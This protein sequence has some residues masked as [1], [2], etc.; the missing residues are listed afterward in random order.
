MKKLVFRLGLALL[1]SV[2]AVC[3]ADAAFHSHPSIASEVLWEESNAL[4]RI[5]NY[6]KENECIPEFW[7]NLRLLLCNYERVGV[8][9]LGQKC[10]KIR[11]EYRT[12]PAMFD[13]SMVKCCKCNG[14]GFFMREVGELGKTVSFPIICKDCVLGFVSK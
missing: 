4:D 9:V 13:Y 8:Q 6:M 7:E 1:V 5:F 12:R 3:Q 10:W 2:G 11:M 14:K